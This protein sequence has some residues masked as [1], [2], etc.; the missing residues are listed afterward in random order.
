MVSVHHETPR[1]IWIW[2][3]TNWHTVNHPSIMSME[4]PLTG[5]GI[6]PSDQDEETCSAKKA[7]KDWKNN[8]QLPVPIPHGPCPDHKDHC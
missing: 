5:D 4:I 8:D 6:N 7:V 1:E 2:R 3:D